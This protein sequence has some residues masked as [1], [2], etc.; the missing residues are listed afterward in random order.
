MIGTDCTLTSID[1]R[2][3]IKLGTYS[4]GASPAQQ[5]TSYR[6]SVVYDQDPQNAIPLQGDIFNLA[7]SQNTILSP[8]NINNSDRFLVLY[9]QLHDMGTNQY[10]TG[11]SLAAGPQS[12]TVNK[13]MAVKLAFKGPSTGGITGIKKGALYFIA[14]SNNN[15]ANTAGTVFA[16]CRTRYT[17]A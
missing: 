3:I 11:G 16:Y 2:Y 10:W 6:I 5:N 14:V 17:D 15:S 4:A 1:L 12:A 9:N 13:H 8:L 7:N